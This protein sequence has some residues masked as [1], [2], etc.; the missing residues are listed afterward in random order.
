EPVQGEIDRFVPVGFIGKDMVAPLDDLDP[1][2]L[3]KVFIDRSP[4]DARYHLIGLSMDNKG[5]EHIPCLSKDVIRLK[6]G[7]NGLVKDNVGNGA[8]VLVLQQVRCGPDGQALD[9]AVTGGFKQTRCSAET[10]A[11]DPYSSGIHRLV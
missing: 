3:L 4:F 11:D 1:F 8:A 5:V 6:I 10:A 2:W 7:E 9:P